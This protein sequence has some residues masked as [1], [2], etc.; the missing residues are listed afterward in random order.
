MSYSDDNLFSEIN[1]KIQ[2]LEQTVN[3]LRNQILSEKSTLD[4][5]GNQLNTLK[6]Q[7]DMKKFTVQQLQKKL[8]EKTKVLNDV[9]S[10]YNKVK[11]FYLFL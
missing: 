4:G 3:N 1:Q 9:R 7:Y 2:E 8:D 11:Y 6:A 10:Y 5:L